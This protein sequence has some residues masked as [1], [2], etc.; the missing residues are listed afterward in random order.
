MANTMDQNSGCDCFVL[1]LKLKLKYGAWLSTF[2]NLNGLVGL[3]S[4]FAWSRSWLN[5][6]V[7]NW[8]VVY[9]PL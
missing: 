4:L 2:I 6:Y 9:L 8:L 1:K 5:K 3:F 7:F